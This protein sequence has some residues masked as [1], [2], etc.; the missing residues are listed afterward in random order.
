M[1][2][3]DEIEKLFLLSSAN[4]KAHTWSDLFSNFNTFT[5]KGLH[6]SN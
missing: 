3:I 2:P 1:F 6:M 5:H 4:N